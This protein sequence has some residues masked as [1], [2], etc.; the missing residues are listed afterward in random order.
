MS[1]RSVRDGMSS[2]LLQSCSASKNEVNGT[3]SAMDVYSGYFYKII[4]KSMREGVFRADT[5]LHILSAKY[6]LLDASEKIET[7]DRRMD[8]ERA[9]ELNQE[10]VDA[11]RERI[12]A[13]SYER[14]IL[15]MGLEYRAALEGLD[16]HV[17]VPIVEI[18]GGGIGEKGNALY[19]FLR[20]DDS[21]VSE[22]SGV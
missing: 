16:E 7:Y 19:R 3:A 5:D 1:V 11:V 4:K 14:V 12:T 9:R 2:L 15:N 13:H 22:A 17:D 6:G 21:A 20:G 18:S 10:V 8:R